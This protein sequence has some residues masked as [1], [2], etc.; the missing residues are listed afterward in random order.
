MEL[1]VDLSQLIGGAFWG[2]L[3]LLVLLGFSAFVGVLRGENFASSHRWTIGGGL[4]I[5]VLWTFLRA[6]GFF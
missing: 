2:C 5:L 1:T 3:A 6:K 4:A